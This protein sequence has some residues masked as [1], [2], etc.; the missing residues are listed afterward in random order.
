MSENVEEP[1]EKRQPLAQLE[2]EDLDCLLDVVQAQNIRQH[3]VFVYEGKRFQFY[4]G[5]VKSRACGILV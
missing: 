2:N 4:F 5:K 1:P 3:T